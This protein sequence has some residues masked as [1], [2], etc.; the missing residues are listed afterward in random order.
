[1]SDTEYRV[2]L[3]TF[4][5]PL[6]LLLYLVRRAEVDIHD[7][8]VA[9]IA[10]QYIEHL[11]GIERVDIETAGEFLLMA[12]TL[13]ELKSRMLTPPAEGG[14]SGGEGDRSRNEPGQDPRRELVRQL[15]EYKR[16]RDA[17]GLLER[18][19]EQ[20][21]SRYPAAGA[22]TPVDDSATDDKLELEDLELAD[23]VEAFGRIIEAVDFRAL[24]SH[25]IHDDDTPTELHAADLVD[26][27]AAR[28]DEGEGEIGLSAIFEGRRRAEMIGLFIALLELVRQQRVGV[29]QADGRV[30]LSLTEDE[31][32][33]DG[34][35]EESGRR[36][37]H[38]ADRHEEEST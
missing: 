19:L 7:I 28:R 21:H 31:G 24:G 12:S 13:M 10:D 29:R 16:F 4:E 23:L 11:R 1:M 9:T 36:E 30:L 8:P 2:E 32:A 37:G 18:R 26:F 22:A 14:G 33:G 38:H 35:E 17:A 27:L 15:L 34:L 3:E 25:E 5:G 6:D 20:W